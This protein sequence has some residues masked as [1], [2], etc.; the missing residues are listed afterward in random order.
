MIRFAT[1]AICLLAGF[2]AAFGWG[3]YSAAYQAFPD[4]LLR[5]VKTSL[6]SEY[7]M[8]PVPQISAER[9]TALTTKA[10]IVMAGDSITA[11]GRW[12]ELFPGASIINRGVPSDVIGGL[13]LRTDAILRAEPEKVFIMIGIN[14][15]AARN[16]DAQIIERYRRV[17]DA[18]QSRGAAVFIQSVINCRKSD[19]S[20]CDDR[21]RKQVFAL[22]AALEQ[23]AD[24]RGAT[25]IDT[26]QAMA[27]EQGFLP[28]Y[29]IDG[30]HP[31]SAGFAKW[32]QVLA[33]YM[34][35]SPGLEPAT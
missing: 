11:S 35:A 4:S 16:S 24:E 7:Q 23:L 33:P 18:L 32:T 26:D 5:D 17:V 13:E 3:Y 22:N 28:Q 10:E 21:M 12:D 15:V 20:S 8:T 29:S 27:D 30:I 9:Y 34:A 1:I 31:S 6:N 19:L 25:F 14:D 2:G